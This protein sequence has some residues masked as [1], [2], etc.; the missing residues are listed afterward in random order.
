M[1]AS[2]NPAILV[3]APGLVGLPG[4]Y[5]SLTFIF[6][7]G[8]EAGDVE[9]M[10]GEQHQVVNL[11]AQPVGSYRV[12]FDFPFTDRGWVLLPPQP[13]KSIALKLNSGDSLYG[14]HK[15]TLFGNIHQTWSAN[16]LATGQ[17]QSEECYIT[18]QDKD[19]LL[20]TPAQTSCNLTVPNLQPVNV[21]L[22]SLRVII[23]GLVTILGLLGLGVYSYLAGV[24]QRW[25]AN[26]EIITSSPERWLRQ[27]TQTWT[28]GKVVLAVTIIALVFHLAYAIFVPMLTSRDSI[29][30]YEYG[31]NLFKTLD[32]EAV[33]LYRTLGYPAF[34]A[35][36]IWLFG[37]QLQGI[38]LLQH[39]AIAILG[40]VTVWFL[41]PRTNPLFSALGGILVGLSPI[42]S[43]T[44][45][46]VWTESTFAITSYLALLIF[47]HYQKKQA[48]IFIAGL[49]VG[50]T[51]MIRP[52]GIILL[53][54]MLAW[55]F[56][57]CWSSLSKSFVFY[58]LVKYS[59]ALIIGYL[60][61][62][63][64]WYIH[65]HSQI[66]RWGLAT[67]TEQTMW[68]N[69]AV[70]GRIPTNLIINHPYQTIWQLTPSRSN[71]HN[72][73]WAYDRNV[74]IATGRLL[75]DDYLFVTESWRESLR[76]DFSK[77]LRNFREA[78]LYNLLQIGPAP[79]SPFIYYKDL[80]TTLEAYN[81][82]EY[83]L[84]LPYAGYSTTDTKT[85]LQ[86]MSYRWEPP[87]SRLRSALLWISQFA[88]NRWRLTAILA[89]FSLPICLFFAPLRPMLLFL[90][91][92]LAGVI[93]TSIVG[94]PVDRYIMVVE[95]A[96]YLLLTILVFT[97]F[98][99]RLREFQ[100]NNYPKGIRDNL[101]S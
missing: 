11:S 81:R 25:E 1:V 3:K 43:I 59:L 21:V 36:T 82:K 51:T 15:L 72:D 44:A 41:Y 5:H 10:W 45:N 30:Y 23:W 35:F 19:L 85:L 49:L 13:L 22:L 29:G 39:L 26:Y 60:I 66:G 6:E 89:L 56:I 28:M 12:P 8:P 54:L 90:L 67:A 52:T 62:T 48:G 34:I 91:Y 70:Q 32:F 74:Q 27:H 20:T 2:S 83:P 92:W 4:N 95:P 53:G 24:I 78:F 87:Q 31:Q 46:L 47:I 68:Y 88:Y 18:L 14:L 93:T 96:L 37:D 61:I 58:Q 99:Y 84:E 75:Q 76:H 55:L 86:R 79:S 57:R 64:P 17:L 7:A 65:F 63:L 101:N 71:Y 9:I 33:S 77:Y 97:L 98:G 100:K 42:I 73:P 50:A 69:T 16:M 94:M 80:S 40:P 38:V